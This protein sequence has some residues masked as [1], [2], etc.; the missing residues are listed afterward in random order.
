M[1]SLYPHKRSSFW[2]MEWI[3]E[4]GIRHN[5]STRLRVDDPAQTRKARAL[6][7]ERT[8]NELRAPA[9]SG[10][11][12]WG[13]VEQFLK[14]RYLNNEGTRE[15]ML[16]AWRSGAVFLRAHAIR[17][18]RGFTRAEAMSYVPWRL[19]PEA[20][21][22]GLRVIKH[23][24][25]LL[26]LKAL[27]VVMREAAVRGLAIANPCV[28]LG[29][30]RDRG[31]IKP[32][33][34]D[35]EVTIIEAALA[36]SDKRKHIEAMRISWQIANAQGCRLSETCI[37]LADV[38]L[39]EGAITFR[40]KGGRDHTAALNPELVPLFTRLK[41]E[42]GEFAF[43]L[44]P[45][46]AKTWWSFLHRLGLKHLSFHCTRV[47]AVN[48]LRRAKVDVRV[49]KDFIGHS[50][51]IIHQIYQRGRRAEQ[52]AATAALSRATS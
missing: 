47:T 17:N 40:A 38:D 7:A 44:P 45:S 48:R 19:G 51:T 2:W 11:E 28:Q 10:G 30:R 21:K 46:F 42:G 37:R 8:T 1:A 12:H 13:W 18:P 35:E 49:A 41:R 4:K 25:A 16:A 3:D 6:C 20:K 34:T 29:I 14:N 31:R 22:A 24:T 27:S 33:I 26:E 15:R 32:E 43:P 39:Q 5:E 50:S 9:R 23:N 52:D 36:A